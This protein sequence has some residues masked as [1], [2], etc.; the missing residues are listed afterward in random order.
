MF[1]TCLWFCSRGG[2]SVKGQGGG[3]SVQGQG[4]ALSRIK[5]GG[6]SVQDQR[7]PSVQGASVQWDPPP[8]ATVRLRAGGTYPTGMHSWL[9]LFNYCYSD[10][11]LKSYQSIK[12]GNVFT[13]HRV[14]WVVRRRVQDFPLLQCE[15]GDVRLPW[16]SW[17]FCTLLACHTYCNSYRLRCLA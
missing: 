7:G 8:S 11:K 1:Y 6:V 15:Q 2:V 5:G 9:Y 3:V 13:L 17:L 10:K 4:G 12:H 14:D 16:G